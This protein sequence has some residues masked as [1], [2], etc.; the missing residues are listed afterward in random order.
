M[1]TPRPTAGLKAPPETP[2]TDHRAGQD[3]EANGQTIE[4]IA[5][6]AFA[7]AEFNTTQA[8]ANVKEEFNDEGRPGG[9]QGRQRRF[10]RNRDDEQAHQPGEQLGDPVGHHVFRV[11]FSAQTRRRA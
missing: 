7:V 2:P 4:R 6:R 3:R 9:M 1:K 5:G 11:A 8:S 10:W